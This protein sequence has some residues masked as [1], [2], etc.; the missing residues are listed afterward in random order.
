MT[1]NRNSDAEVLT[2][3]SVGLLMAASCVAYVAVIWPVLVW[4][5]LH[6]NPTWMS[7]RRALGG[8]FRWLK[9]GLHGSPRDVY[10]WRIYHDAVPPK[11]VF[12]ALDVLLVLGLLAACGLIWMWVDRWRR[13]RWVGRRAWDPRR[14]LTPRSWAAPRDLVHLQAPRSRSSSRIRRSLA[15]LQ[16][17]VYRER[18][19]PD[20]AG[21]DSWPLGSLRGAELRSRPETHLLVVAPTRAGKSTRVVIPAA[22]EHDGPAVILSNKTDVVHNTIQARSRRG[23]VWLYAP[24]TDPGSLPVAPCGWSPLRGCEVWNYALRMSQWMFDADPSGAATSNQ[25]GGAR[26]YNREAV[27]VVLPPVLQA[28]ALGGRTMADVLRWLRSG[29]D[30]LDEPRALLT[31]HGE[32]APADQ[33]VGVQALEERPRSLLLM[34]AAQLVDVYRFPALQQ[35]DRPDFDPGEL[36]GGGTLYLVAPDSERDALAPVFAG[37]LGAILRAWECSAA[38][39]QAAPSTLKILADEAAHLAPLSKLPSYLA[40]SGGWGVRWCLVYQSLSQ[41]QARYNGEA[42]AVLGNALAKLFLGP[43]HDEATRRYLVDL[44]DDETTMVT[45]SHGTKLGFEHSKTW[46]ERQRNKVSAQALMQLG[47]GEA[48]MVHGRDLPAITHLPAWWEMR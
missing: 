10:G 21:G 7:L 25:S 42:D 46:A 28:A 9:G 36:L 33:L 34:S 43:I 12:I 27:G 11:G 41:L 13:R 3:A 40:V 14:E 6:A 8:G 17:L 4:S 32:F 48:V 29:V 26:F 19:A 35:A 38:T 30:G 44:L 47:T 22:R 45:S 24:M 23:P 31:Q 15:A 1:D 20:P 16:R 37:V 2:V 5:T 18:H 39:G